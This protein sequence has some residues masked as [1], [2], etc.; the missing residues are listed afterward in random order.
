[1]DPQADGTAAPPRDAATARGRAAVAASILGVL[2]I[3][4]YFVS[5]GGDAGAL[6]GEYLVNAALLV[7]AFWFPAM[8][9][10]SPADVRRQWIA[11]VVWFG[12]WTLVWDLA[13]SGLFDRRLFQEWW[14]VYPSGVVLFMALLVLHGAAVGR[15]VARGR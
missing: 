10:G 13:T 3:G 9:V 7:V 11:L 14:L 5:S 15:V 12:A 4:S 2:L 6:P 1:M 8:R